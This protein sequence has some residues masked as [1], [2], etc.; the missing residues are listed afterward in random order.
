VFR[1]LRFVL[2]LSVSLTA[3]SGCG[4]L[5]TDQPPTGGG[6]SYSPDPKQPNWQR[7]LFGTKWIGEGNPAPDPKVI[8]QFGDPPKPS[9]AMQ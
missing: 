8:G 1:F 6:L 2:F 3:T 5:P 4:L 7:L 9:V